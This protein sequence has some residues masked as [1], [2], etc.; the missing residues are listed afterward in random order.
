MRA[1]TNIRHLALLLLLGLAL[2]AGAEERE[3][4]TDE[5]P[6]WMEAELE[7]ARAW[8]LEVAPA[9]NYGSD[10]PSPDEVV[11]RG[12]PVAPA[13]SQAPTARLP[14]PE[15]L[16]FDDFHE[17]LAPYGSWVH[18]PEYGRVFVPARTIQ[19]EGWR[20]YL[21]G[22]WVWTRYGWTW[23]SDEPF[24]WA[25]YHYG[26]WGFRAGIGWFWVPGYTWGPAWV[27]WRHGPDS[28]GW[29]P[30]YPGYVR[31]TAS[32][33]I[34]VDHW[35]FVGHAHFHGHP[36]HRH[37]QRH[38]HHRHFHRSHW[39]KH[40]RSSGRVYA[41]PPRT[42][43][44]RRVGRVHEVSIVHS[45]RP[46]PSRVV[47][48]EGRR[49]VEIYRPSAK[50]AIRPVDRRPAPAKVRASRPSPGSGLSSGKPNRTNVRSTPPQRATPPRA[51]PPQRTR[52]SQR[53]TSPQ[54]ATPPQRS[55]PPQRATPPQ[56][57]ARPD[58][59]TAPQRTGSSQRATPPQRSTSSQRAAPSQRVT[60]PQRTPRPSV[61][62]RRGGAS[63]R[64][65][66]SP[67]GRGSRVGSSSSGRSP[68]RA[69]STVRAPSRGGAKSAPAPA[70][71]RR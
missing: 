8:K 6:D 17:G 50:G 34:H 2:P 44:E 53:A 46:A 7:D 28:I 54:R 70:R 23:V 49:R 63:Q 38:H 41:G 39:A 37:W 10:I 47:S 11:G 14:E 13:P 66:A 33:P 21:H 67:A 30:L 42:W 51:T 71:A 40:W 69:K 19:V 22:Q 32:Y 24:G 62:A 1:P 59:A 31:V 27:A 26:R 56:R 35:I 68:S 12:A 20:P 16:S 43:V 48:V 61:D 9:G 65:V 36:I 55:T 3:E 25:T 29:A 52:S 45:R 60:S 57:T 4:V 15:D 64:S 18:T 5:L 58:R